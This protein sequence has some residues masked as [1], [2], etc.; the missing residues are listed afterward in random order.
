MLE[1]DSNLPGRGVYAPREARATDT[2]T[3]EAEHLRLLVRL[4]PDA[5]RARGSRAEP[6][7]T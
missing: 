2:V 7:W 6:R 1:L 5:T 3:S 4:K